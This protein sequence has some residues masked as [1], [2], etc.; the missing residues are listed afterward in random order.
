M[1]IRDLYNKMVDLCVDTESQEA[2]VNHL[3]LMKEASG[4]TTKNNKIFDIFELALEKEEFVAKASLNNLSKT[5]K[6]IENDDAAD[7]CQEILKLL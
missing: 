7:L 6:D 1:K 4:L 3:K 5:L 2:L